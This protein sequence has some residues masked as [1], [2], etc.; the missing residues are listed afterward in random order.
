MPLYYNTLIENINI[1]IS[2]SSVTNLDV[3]LYR[4]L[5]ITVFEPNLDVQVAERVVNAIFTSRLDYCNSL[6]AGRTVQDFTHLQRLQNAA[7]RCVLMIPLDSSAKYMCDLHWLPVH[8][9]VHY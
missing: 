7:S 4:N 5:K 6:L 8:K 2:S 1:K 3:S 9:Q